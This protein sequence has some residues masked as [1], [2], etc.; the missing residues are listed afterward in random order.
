MLAESVKH[1]IEEEKKILPNFNKN[2][3]P[4]QL[5]IQGNKF[6]ELNYLAAVD[7]NVIPEL[8]I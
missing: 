7:N 6:L 4:Q 5:A 2:S 1:R 8:K 3:K